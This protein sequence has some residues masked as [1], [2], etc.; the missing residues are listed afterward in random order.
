VLSSTYFSTRPQ[1]LFYNSVLLVVVLNKTLTSFF[2]CGIKIFLDT[3]VRIA[4]A[5]LWHRV[6]WY[7]VTKEYVPSIFKLYLSRRCLHIRHLNTEIHWHIFHRKMVPSSEKEL[8]CVVI[9]LLSVSY[10]H[11]FYYHSFHNYNNTIVIQPVNSV[12]RSHVYFSVNRD[13]HKN[14]LCGIIH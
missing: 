9:V 8:L 10:N 13:R 1:Q 3:K 2:N 4:V 12:C 5:A 6:L 11:F 14:K 7:V